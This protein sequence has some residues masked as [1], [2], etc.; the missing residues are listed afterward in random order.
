MEGFEKH[1][2][3]LMLQKGAPLHLIEVQIHKVALQAKR[4]GIETMIFG[5]AADA[6][7]G[8]QSNILSRDWKV[9]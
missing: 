8:G 6:V 7:Y 1:S 3:M 9:G 4:D 2:D 5:E